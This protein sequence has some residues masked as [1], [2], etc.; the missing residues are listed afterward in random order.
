MKKLVAILGAFLIITGLKAQKTVV[1]KETQKPEVTADTI[2]K[3][4]ATAG[5]PGMQKELKYSG[6]TIKNSGKLAP[7]LK[8]TPAAKIAP[9]TKQ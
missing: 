9:A 5:K 3:L 2:K 8:N 1:R 4:N 7:A 6:S